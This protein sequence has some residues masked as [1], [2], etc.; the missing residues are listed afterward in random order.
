MTELSSDLKKM[1]QCPARGGLEGGEVYNPPPTREG[2]WRGFTNPPPLRRRP[3]A[4]HVH[5]KVEITSM[6][7]PPQPPSWRGGGLEPPPKKTRR[8]LLHL[9]KLLRT[10]TVYTIHVERL[11]Y[12]FALRTAVNGVV[13]VG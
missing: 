9:L 2:F 11:V 6:A 7:K 5:L 12:T 13:E 10:S 1:E 3:H 4:N 8:T